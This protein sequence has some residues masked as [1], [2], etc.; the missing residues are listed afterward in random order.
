MTRRVVLGREVWGGNP[1]PQCVV[2]IRFACKLVPLE[3][4]EGLVGVSPA[5]WIPRQPWDGGRTAVPEEPHGLLVERVHEAGLRL[6]QHRVEH[7]AVDGGGVVPQQDA[8]A[9]PLGR[10]RASH[11]TVQR[12]GTPSEA[13]QLVANGNT[14]RVPSE[15]HNS[16]LHGIKL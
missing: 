1:P 15:S 5:V 12:P 10:D 2:C 4:C 3:N 8:D 14:R 7:G 6:L 11:D 16:I 9:H 13:L